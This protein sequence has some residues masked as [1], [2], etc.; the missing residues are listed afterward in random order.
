MKRTCK[1]SAIL[2]TA[3]WG[4]L[5]TAVFA[6]APAPDRAGTPAHTVK[7]FFTAMAKSDFAA[8]KKHVQSKELQQ[9]I[10]MVENLTKEVPEMKAD[11]AKEYA[12]MVR[13]KYLAETI[14]GNKA[15]V[16]I[17]Y[18]EKNKVKK[19]TYKLEKKGKTWVITE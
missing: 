7:S 16:Q 17:S 9:L 3:V 14:T 4:L 18:Q 8:A 19:E 12:P 15:V 2:L 11:T 6:A 1:H 13:A 10:G 5:Q